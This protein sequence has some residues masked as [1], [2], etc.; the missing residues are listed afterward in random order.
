M[1]CVSVKGFTVLA[2]STTPAHFLKLYIIVLKVVL[3]T[4]D[5]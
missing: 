2:I 3:K 4:M 1:I 5:L